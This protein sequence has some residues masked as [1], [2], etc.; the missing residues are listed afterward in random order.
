M[1][2]IRIFVYECTECGN[3]EK[4]PSDSSADP[5]VHLGE[6]ELVYC[7]GCGEDKQMRF[8]GL[9]GITGKEDD[10]VL[11][12]DTRERFCPLCSGPCKNG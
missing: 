11:D 1:V 12:S 7:R 5:E 10:F 4:F 6:T 2:Q 8:L 3:R 9:E